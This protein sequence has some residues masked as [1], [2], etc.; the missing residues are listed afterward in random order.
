MKTWIVILGIYSV[1]IT[2]R[3]FVFHREFLALEKDCKELRRLKK[4][5]EELR[6]EI[7]TQKIYAPLSMRHDD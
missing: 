5:N 6:K 7:K 3:H 1:V 4:E 2:I